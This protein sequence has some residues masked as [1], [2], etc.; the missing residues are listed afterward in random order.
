MAQLQPARQNLFYREQDSPRFLSDYEPE[1]EHFHRKCGSD[2]QPV[3]EAWP[4]VHIDHEHS[5]QVVDYQYL[6]HSQNHGVERG[7]EVLDDRPQASYRGE[8]AYNPGDEAVRAAEEAGYEADAV[9]EQGSQGNGPAYGNSEHVHDE[10][11]RASQS[12]PYGCP[13]SP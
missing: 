12:V 3:P 1:F 11:S 10:V 9:L 4:S 5:G 6:V 13:D 2:V 7:P 8:P